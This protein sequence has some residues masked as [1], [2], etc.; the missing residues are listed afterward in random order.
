MDEW[1]YRQHL[2]NSARRIRRA[3][4]AEDAAVGV[5]RW[6]GKNVRRREAAETAWHRVVPPRWAD[7]TAILNI[8]AGTL[9]VSVANAPLRFELMRRT[10][11]LERQLAAQAGGLKRIRFV[12]TPGEDTPHDDS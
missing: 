3:T 4:R 5:L 11:Q 12:H 10:P 7:Q 2:E 9:I 1:Q 8:D 6:V